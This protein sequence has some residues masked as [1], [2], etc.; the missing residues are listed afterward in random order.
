L[1]PSPQASADEITNWNKITIEATK[2]GVNPADFDLP[3]QPVVGP[4]LNSNLA[5]RVHAIEA[6]AVY[7][8]VNAIAPIGAPYGGFSASVSRPA[9]AETAVAQAAYDVL[10]NVP[11]LSASQT[12]ALQAQRPV[13]DQLLQK[14]LSAVTDRS[15]QANGVALGHF[16]A[17]HILAVRK[18]DK[19]FPN[20]SYTPAGW[21]GVNPGAG[22]WRPTPAVSVASLQPG[23]NQQWGSVTPFALTSDDQFR[24]QPPPAIG[25]PEYAAALKR[26]EAIG[27]ATSTVRTADQAHIAQFYKQDA[28]LTVNEAARLLAEGSRNSLAQNALVFA[29]LDIATAD[30]RFATWDAKYAYRLW[31]PVASINAAQLSHGDYKVDLPA[32]FDY[33]SAAAW[34]PLLDTPPHPSY[35]AGHAATV[36]AGI[37]VLKKYFGDRHTLTLHTATPNE[38]ARTVAGLSRIIEENGLSRLYGGIHYPFDISEGNRLGGKVAD[39]VLHNSLRGKGDGH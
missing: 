26:V 8:A 30:A 22:Q 18:A 29:L 3:G 37:E 11:G 33:S 19:S 4:G 7:D 27:S 13:L 6:I 17:G 35:V 31:R 32:T 36:A 14:T 1:L 38:P 24:P 12:A 9:A 2:G 15:A 23:I 10:L 34:K 5:T 25:K 20:E 16:A 21:P 39:F 28:E